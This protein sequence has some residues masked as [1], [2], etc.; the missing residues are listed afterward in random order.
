MFGRLSQHGE[1]L[2]LLDLS[3]SVGDVIAECW[4]LDCERAVSDLLVLLLICFNVMLLLI[5]TFSAN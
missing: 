3:D 1:S 5:Q 4:V 2:L